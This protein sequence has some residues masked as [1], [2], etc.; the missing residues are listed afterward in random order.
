MRSKLLFISLFCLL[1]IASSLSYGQ[2]NFTTEG[3]LIRVKFNQAAIDPA[4]TLGYWYNGTATYDSS[5]FY[6]EHVQAGENEYFITYHRKFPGG[7]DHMGFEIMDWGYSLERVDDYN[8]K[9]GIYSGGAYIECHSFWLYA[10]SQ[11][12]KTKNGMWLLAGGF[13]NNFISNDGAFHHGYLS[14]N[15]DSV[16][17]L[18]HIVGQIGD[19]YAAVFF[20]PDSGKY[21]CSLF[22]ID[23]SPFIDALEEITLSDGMLPEQIMHIS[24][25]LYL[26]RTA[27]ICYDE[28]YGTYFR[29]YS[30]EGSQLKLLK[31]F[32]NLPWNSAFESRGDKFLFFADSIS[33]FTFNESD[34]SFIHEQTIPKTM[35]YDLDYKYGAK[36]SGDS[37]Y[38]YDAYTQEKLY[39]IYRNG[40]G[41]LGNMLV[42]SPYVYIHHVSR[43]IGV[44]DDINEN[45]NLTYK[46]SAYPNPFNPQT[47]IA[48]TIPN[49]GKVELAVYDLLG[50][51]V[52]EL[53]NEYRDK[54]SYEVKFDGDNLAS[55]IYFYTIKTGSFVK[56]NKLILLK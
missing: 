16:N 5:R 47:T 11:Y 14:H 12:I 41:G 44:A 45:A 38:I 52:T 54:G 21:F 49:A 2:Q 9:H 51:K 23:N 35:T 18:Q 32:E 31:N 6:S 19:N 46:L 15:L 53:L 30:L 13:G 8:I 48:F 25:G 34:S 55:G 39:S 33:T 40:V 42:D 28:N 26:I 29:L 37:L 4:D 10:G 43:T 56:T 50:R 20:N 24:G 22:D 17:E 7:T 3:N 1:I 27:G 36:L